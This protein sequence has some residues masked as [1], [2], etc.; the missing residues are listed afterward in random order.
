MAGHDCPGDEL[1][2]PLDRRRPLDR[3]A[4]AEERRRAGLDEVAGEEDVGVGTMTTMSLSVWPR[5][6]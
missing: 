4:V 3:I 5:P 2:H 1:D 6:R